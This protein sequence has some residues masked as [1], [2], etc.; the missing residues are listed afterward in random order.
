[1]PNKVTEYE[2]PFSFIPSESDITVLL[3]LPKDFIVVY[4]LKHCQLVINESVRKMRMPYNRSLVN[5][6]EILW[7]LLDND[8]TL[9]QLQLRTKSLVI[10]VQ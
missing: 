10:R 3:P 4:R 1:M 2:W 8:V 7:L 9:E 6:Q 5:N